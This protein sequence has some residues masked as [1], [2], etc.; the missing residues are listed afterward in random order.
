MKKVYKSSALKKA[1]E[2]LQREIARSVTLN[3]GACGIVLK[4]NWQFSEEK[5]KEV[6]IKAQELW[7]ICAESN[8][9]SMPQ[10]LEDATGIELRNYEGKSWHDLPYLNS[11]AWDR[12]RPSEPKMIAIRY[13]QAKWLAVCVLSSVLLAIWELYH[14]DEELATAYVK[15]EECK[16]KHGNDEH[17]IAELAYE[18]VGIK[19][20]VKYFEG[21]LE[22]EKN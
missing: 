16:H 8:E 3:F 11:S 6:Y 10:M 21:S 2:A 5:I 15:I 17:E 18:L 9:I 12:Q 13:A 1:N 4:Q 22:D 20:F 14:W 7:N 19:D